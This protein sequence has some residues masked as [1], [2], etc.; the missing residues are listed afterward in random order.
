MVGIGNPLHPVRCP[1]SE[2]GLLDSALGSRHL[3]AQLSLLR[4]FFPQH[5]PNKVH[6][7]LDIAKMGRHAGPDMFRPPGKRLSGMD[8]PDLDDKC[9]THTISA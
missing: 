8:I 6:K 9:S 1:W 7:L 4:L 2:S 3:P 5:S